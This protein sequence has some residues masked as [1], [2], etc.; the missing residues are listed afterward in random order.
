M[1]QFVKNLC[2]AAGLVVLPAVVMADGGAG[3]YLAGRAAMLTND[4]D[5]AARYYTRALGRDPSNVSLMEGATL[6]FSASGQMD[7][8]ITIARRLDA[9]QPNNPFATPILMAEAIVKG[10]FDRASQHLESDAIAPL[11]QELARAWVKA[12]AGKMSEALT[13]FRA[14]S[15]QSGLEEFGQYH[16]ALAL[17][18]VGDME[19]ADAVLS[20]DTAQGLTRSKRPLLL[21]AQILAQLDRAPDALPALNNYLVFGSDA[22]VLAMRDAI[23]AGQDVPFTAV[24]GAADGIA[25]VYFG[26]AQALAGEAEDMLTLTYSRLAEYLRPDLSDAVLLSA[27]LLESMGQF[28]LATETYDRISRDDPAYYSAALGRANAMRRSDREE[29]AVAVLMELTQEF[30]EFSSGHASLGDTY[31]R[32]ERYDEASKAY[33]SAIALLE[34]TE[35]EDWFLYY[36]RAIAH[37][38]EGRWSLAEPDFRKALALNPDHPSV[39]NYLGYSY[40]EMQINLD[41]AL[42]MIETAV[43]LR[44]RDGYI[45]DSLGWVYYRLGRYNEAVEWMERATQLMPVDPIINDH[46]GDV[47][48]AVGRKREAQFQWMRALS[49]E[50]E[51]ADAERMRRKL[52]VGLDVVLSEEGAE[53]LHPENDG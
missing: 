10:Q 45:T 27:A 12:G 16:L 37:E 47:Y 44:P 53:P 50:P 26:V 43:N 14:L 40:V 18:S 32:L 21:H 36:V 20:S 34:G 52:E 48:W 42:Q 3:P 22:G 33:D 8:A 35:A 28:D 17:A 30:P 5:D 15:E 46:L 25:E 19:G 31:R 24:A 1:R 2:L 11:I 29:D 13:D 41:E 7:R 49:F 38:R 51:E 23:A 6:A 4:F 39:L 9:A